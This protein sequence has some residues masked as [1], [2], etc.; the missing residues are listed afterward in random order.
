LVIF[1]AEIELT[2]KH[3]FLS[4]RNQPE[5]VRLLLSVG[6]DANRVS[7]KTCTPLM[8]ATSHSNSELT[9]VR[10]PR[11]LVH[12]DFSPSLRAKAHRIGERLVVVRC[13][14]T[15]GFRWPRRTGTGF[16]RSCTQ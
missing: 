3:Y 9:K 2:K 14:W 15:P 7:K 6:A 8:Y 1:S 16:V 13:C 11:Q 12:I 4:V 10:G 5:V